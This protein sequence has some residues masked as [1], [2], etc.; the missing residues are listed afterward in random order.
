MRA[1]PTITTYSDSA[2][3]TTGQ[4]NHGTSGNGVADI[5]RDGFVVDNDIT[6]GNIGGVS[7]YYDAASEL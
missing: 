4:T 2:K 7:F 6:S 5:K 3:T 1:A